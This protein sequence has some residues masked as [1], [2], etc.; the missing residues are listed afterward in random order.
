MNHSYLVFPDDKVDPVSCVKPGID[1]VGSLV[2]I[3]IP[4]KMNP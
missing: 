4:V 3:C 1:R 2:V